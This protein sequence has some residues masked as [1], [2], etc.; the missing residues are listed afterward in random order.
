[1]RAEEEVETDENETEKQE[2]DEN[3]TEKQEEHLRLPA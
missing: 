1:M 3:K 2:K